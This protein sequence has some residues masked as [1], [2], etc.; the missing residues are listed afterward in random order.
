[1]DNIAQKLAI[2]STTFDQDPRRA[3]VGARSN[4]FTGIEFDA[5]SPTLDLTQLSQTGRREFR[6]MLAAND[7]PLAERYD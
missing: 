4:G 5:I 6:H 3:A 7:L 2:V 1:M